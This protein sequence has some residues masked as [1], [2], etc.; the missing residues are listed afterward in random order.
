MNPSIIV[1]SHTHILPKFID[2][3]P[4]FEL[5]STPPGSDGTYRPGIPNAPVGAT[6]S[7]N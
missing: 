1:D 6:T 4:F 2:N 3:A 5:A 7:I